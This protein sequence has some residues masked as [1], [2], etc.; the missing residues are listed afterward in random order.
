MAT[1]WKVVAISVAV[2]LLALCVIIF[3]ALDSKQIRRQSDY[4]QY[5]A[6]ELSWVIEDI[7]EQISSLEDEREYVKSIQAQ[8]LRDK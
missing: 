3:Y 8:K 2:L 6:A 4:T 1:V 7:Q 5:D